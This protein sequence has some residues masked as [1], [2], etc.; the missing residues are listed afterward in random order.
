[1]TRDVKSPSAVIFHICTHGIPLIRS[2]CIVWTNCCIIRYR[3]KTQN[4]PAAER[5]LI[6]L[7]TLL[8]SFKS[9]SQRTSQS[10]RLTRSQL[11]K[12]FIIKWN[13]FILFRFLRFPLISLLDQD[14]SVLYHP[15]LMKGLMPV[16]SPPEEQGLCFLDYVWTKN[17]RNDW[18][19]LD[20]WLSTNL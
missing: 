10:C 19:R 16:A 14:G 20:V 5:W 12:C 8:L 9:F 15:L 7:S 2:K 13:R 18:R 3:L 4:G 1:M 6:S 17:S 11:L